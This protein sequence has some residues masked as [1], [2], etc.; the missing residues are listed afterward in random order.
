MKHSNETVAFIKRIEITI[1]WSG[2]RKDI[3]C[4][5]ILHAKCKHYLWKKF[6]DGYNPY[7][8]GDT[9]IKMAMEIS[10]QDQYFICLDKGQLVVFISIKK[11]KKQNIC[12]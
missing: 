9:M 4:L 2:S 1:C 10:T 5:K 6:G 3:L 7:R 12:G 11:G 8:Y